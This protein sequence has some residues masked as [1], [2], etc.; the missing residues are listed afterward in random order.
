MKLINVQYPPP[1]PHSPKYIFVEEY[2]L[3]IYQ[4]VS[5][6][7]CNV[8]HLVYKTTSLLIGRASI[9][10]PLSLQGNGHIEL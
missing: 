10:H 8:T 1:L 2:S 6:Q 3:K 5:F 7:M 9:V 4:N